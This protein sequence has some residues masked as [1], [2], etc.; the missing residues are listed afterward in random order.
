M[1][2]RTLQSMADGFVCDVDEDGEIFFGPVTEL[3]VQR[4]TVVAALLPESSLEDIV[5]QTEQS[6]DCEVFFG[7]VTEVEQRI[8]LTIAKVPELETSSAV[9]SGGLH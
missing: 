2:D 4:A 8:H 6:S 3:E 5:Q 9:N 7:E 1:T